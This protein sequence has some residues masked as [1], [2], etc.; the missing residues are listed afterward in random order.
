MTGFRV[1]ELDYDLPEHLIAQEPV[2]KR[3]DSRL[4]VLDRADGGIADK[5][6]AEL[7]SLLRPDDTLVLNE[8]RVVPAKIAAR[9]R[10]GGKID[11]LFVRQLRVGVW[12]VMLRGRGR[13]RRGEVLVVDRDEADTTLQLVESLGGGRW[14]VNVKPEMEAVELLEQIG[15]PPLPP[16]IRRE[17]PGDRRDTNDAARYQTVYAGEPGAVAAPTAGMHFT[18]QMLAEIEALGVACVRL[19]LHVG[20]GTF[21][22][23]KVDDLANHDMHEEWY[24]LTPEVTSII[25]SRRRAGGR[26]VAVGTTAVRALESCASDDGSLKPSEGWTHVFCY[27]PHRFGAV[28]ALLTN[29]HLPR[30]TLLAMVMAFAG[31]D[32]V[33]DAYR[34][35]IEQQYRFYSYGDA[36]LIL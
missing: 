13:L 32:L 24:K 28:D 21:A 4:L 19:T 27:P 16:Y 20:L 6:F 18:G 26:T 2:A 35:A 3:G 14:H 7:P 30:S 36:M 22:P 29:F 23:I 12:E 15:R 17:S 11:G 34:H 31:V 5:R 10:T 9:R 33:R 25:N 1:T 8:T